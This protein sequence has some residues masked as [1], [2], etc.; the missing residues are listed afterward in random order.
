MKKVKFF[1]K[2]AH[3]IFKSVSFDVA[4]GIIATHALVLFFGYYP[5]EI[6][7]YL[8]GILMA[9]LPDIDTLY[10][11]RRD[12]FYADHRSWPHYPLLMFLIVV[13]AVSLWSYFYFGYISYFHLLLA[14][15]CLFW[16]YLHDSWDNAENEEGIQWGAPF[17][18]YN[19]YVISIRPLEEKNKSWFVLTRA[20]MRRVTDKTIRRVKEN[21]E[22]AIEFWE[23]HYMK[24]TL[25]AYQ[26]VIILVI[27]ILFVWIV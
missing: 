6:T 20:F 16:H 11:F 13:S 24:E 1:L 7:T 23:K 14:S 4:I 8:F 25:E 10:M 17:F 12:K 19:R 3:A 18:S 21:R 27:A 22:T 2:T 9:L 26:G 15:S 5:E